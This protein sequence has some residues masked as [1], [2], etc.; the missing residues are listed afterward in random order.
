M[1]A[2]SS[3]SETLDAYVRE[4]RR[5]VDLGL[6]ASETVPRIEEANHGILSGGFR[7]PDEYRTLATGVP[8]TR[9][10]VAQCPR[11]RFSVIAILWGPFQETRVHDHLNWCVVKVLEGLCH[12]VDYDRLDDESRPGFAELAIRE[13][14][15]V[16]AGTVC[17]L[18][19][20][21]RTNIHK[22]A[23]ATAG[24]SISLHT[25]GDPGSR[26]R[27]FD[28]ASGKVEIVDLQFHNR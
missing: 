23:N 14:Q 11:H 2:R 18:L 19:P 1:N 13:T 27:V 21:A 16:P 26:A 7:L 25:Y 22:M 6:P 10:L 17:G 24:T 5:I 15:L 3:D 12:A 20:P 28:P 9:N 8:Y 4:V